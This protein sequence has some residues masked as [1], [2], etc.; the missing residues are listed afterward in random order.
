MLRSARVSLCCPCFASGPGKW[1]TRFRWHSCSQSKAR[2]ASF[3]AVWPYCGW[4]VGCSVLWIC[5]LIWECFIRRCGGSRQHVHNLTAWKKRHQPASLCRMLCISK[6]WKWSPGSFTYQTILLPLNYGS[7]L[8][9]PYPPQSL[10]GLHKWEQ[11]DTCL[12]RPKS[13][14]KQVIVLPPFSVPKQSVESVV[15]GCKTSC[16]F[17]GDWIFAFQVQVA[18]KGKEVKLAG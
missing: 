16:V 17:S 7:V 13:S 11:S 4:C 5:A 6:S 10:P 14:L 15:L 18:L 1:V 9:F 8:T 12:P 2:D 3:P